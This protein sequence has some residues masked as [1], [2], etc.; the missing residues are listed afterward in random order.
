MKY[1]LVQNDEHGSLTAFFDGQMYVADNTHA[2]WPQLV[3]QVTAANDSTDL[4]AL[5]RLFDPAVAVADFFTKVSE[6]VSVAGG[7]VFF[8]GEEVNDGLADHIIRFMNEGNDALPLVNFM[9]NI[10]TNPNEHSRTQLFDWLSK[11]D[12]TITPEGNFL[13]YKGVAPR[14]SGDNLDKYPYQS[15]SR[16]KA[17]VDGKVYDGA[18][19][20]GVG[21]VVEMPRGDVA[22]DPTVA[23]HTGLHAGN[24][25]Y[26]S[27][28]S[29]GA[30]LIVEINPRDVVSVPHD[31]NSEKIRCCR[32]T[33]KEVNEKELT[34]SYFGGYS[35]PVV[36]DLDVD[37]SDESDYDY[38]DDED[39]DY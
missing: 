4:T 33:V 7:H 14:T 30:L 17:V 37:Y 25:R 36:D 20:N 10:M 11:R 6:R 29:Q 5:A 26:A 27:S 28:F 1:N 39:D 12:F 31:S 24:Y 38:Y 21:A 34:T 3:A 32:Y 23:C 15:I 19:P 18:I 9:E 22:H 35:A 8:D 2:S 16:G 13:A